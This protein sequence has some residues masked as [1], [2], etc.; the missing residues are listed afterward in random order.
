MTG[1]HACDRLRQRQKLR[2]RNKLI[3]QFRLIR[4]RTQ[5]AAD[6]HFKAELFPSRGFIHALLG[7]E[8]EVMQSSQTAGM[9]RASAERRLELAAKILAVGMSKQELRKR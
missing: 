1:K 7:D 8:P 9:L 3:K 4:D 2:R 6:V 5:A